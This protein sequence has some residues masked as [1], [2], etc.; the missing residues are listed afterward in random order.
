MSFLAKN[1]WP[2]C[3]LAL[4]AS[5]IP[6]A[7]ASSTVL[8]AQI[9]PD[10][11]LGAESSIVTPEALIRGELADEIGGGAIRGENL[12]HSFVEFNVL[13]DQRVYFANPIA[14]ENILSRVTGNN[15]SN[16]DGLLGVNGA[17]NL[18]L[19]NPNGIIFGPNARLDIQGSFTATTAE[20]IS[21]ADDS[22]FSATPTG[23]ELLSVSVPLGVQFN[24]QPQGDITQQGDLTVG[25]SETLTLF[26]DTVLNSGDLT[27]EGGTVQ[28]L[29]NQVSVI[30]QAAMDV[31][32]PTEAGTVQIGGDYQGQGPLP[33]ANVTLVEAGVIINADARQAGDGGR[34]IVWADGTTQ[35][36]GSIS[37]QG[38]SD[39]GDGG[40]VEV[41]G[42]QSLDFTG[43]VNTQAVNGTVGQLLLDPANIF[44]ANTAPA[45]TVTVGLGNGV[46]TDFIYSAVEDPGQNSHL[47]P[48]T[49]EALLAV[50]DLT[51]A[52]ENVIVVFDDVSANSDTDLTL[53]ATAIGV[54]GSLLE[55]SGGGSLVLETPQ[56]TGNFVVIDDG[57]VDTSPI[58][59][60][61]ALGGNVRITTHDLE[62]VNDGIVSASTFADVDA[63]QVQIN[64]TGDVLVDGE[65]SLITS[66]VAPGATGDS[67][68]VNIV[69]NNLSVLNNAEV[70]AGTFEQG[71]AGQ[72]QISVT[73][74]VLLDG[75]NSVI[76]SQVNSG[77]TG[78]SG[79]IFLTTNNLSVLNDAQVSAGTFGDGDA[80]QVQ[81]TTMGDVLLDGKN[82]VISSQV[83][84]GAIGD[85]GGIVLSTNN[86]SVLNGSVVTASTFG[87]G[88]AGPVQI[89][90]ADKILIDGDGSFLVSGVFS[91]AT[92]DS[93]G[94]V[95]SAN[96]LSVLNDAE[97]GASTFSEGDTGLVQIT[98]KGDVL[99]D[100]ENS[101]IA[102]QVNSS[103]TG[104]SGG[105]ILSAN[106]LSIFNNAAVS[107]STFSEGNAGQVQI[108]ATGD[109]LVDG[110]GSLI[111]SKVEPGATGDSG[112]ILLTGKSVSITN[113]GVISASTFGA[114]NSGQIRMTARG[115]VLVDG[116]RSAITSQVN[117]GGTGNSGGILLSA[118][119][120]SVFNDAQISGSTFGDGDAGQVQIA[121]IGDV[122]VDGPGSFIVSQVGRTATGNSNGIVLSAST[123]AL[124]NRGGVSASTVG[125][126]NS[127]QIKITSTEQV[128]VEDG[129]FL[130]SQVNSE[131]TGD[132]N[133]IQLST[134]HLT[135]SD[136]GLISAGTFGQG[137]AGNVL[138]RSLNSG[139]L[140]ITLD[141]GRIRA[142]TR[143]ANPGG[144]LTLQTDGDLTIQGKGEISVESLEADSGAAGS[145][146]VLAEN[147]LLDGAVELSAQTASVTGGG[148]INFTVDDALVM[149]RGSFI[150]AESTNPLGGDGG[151]VFIDTGFLIGAPGENNDIIAN[152]VGGN[153]GRIEVN[154][155]NIFGFQESQSGDTATLRNNTTNDLSASSGQGI[156][157]EVALNT[158]NVD[159]AS[160]LG[161]LPEGPIDAS[162]LINQ[163]LCEA[164]QG[165]EFTVTGR[166]GLPSAPTDAL[167]N[168]TPWEDWSFTE[169]TAIDK[170]LNVID[171]DA[172][173]RSATRLVEAQGAMRAADG[174]I[175]LLAE[176]TLAT[177]IAANSLSVSCRTVQSTAPAF[178]RISLP[179]SP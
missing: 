111:A 75:K 40:F 38:G 173:D 31:S 117:S 158:L 141:D 13:Q 23:N 170:T 126:G 160:G 14:I 51:L 55:Q 143:S 114:G 129:A 88:D 41:S 71:N 134:N 84:S 131:A 1:F 11:S 161:Q 177:P 153:G 58:P 63:G 127:G 50:N 46:F 85:S 94:I 19:M 144:N 25:A 163:S 171:V 159:P 7:E 128:I 100:G 64:A 147:V 155:I 107:A 65:F 8:V 148:I 169:D 29:G 42:R 174:R 102:S 135:V 36:A 142:R 32:A 97:L 69:A 104:N 130:I 165:S 30:G 95:L 150:N 112:G 74:D 15:L 116:R 164:G 77:A 44:I 34:V 152:A 175:V 132:S 61:T 125:D 154:A 93:G 54:I 27:T 167:G 67:G 66:R 81:I 172:A 91:G 179:P 87:E 73:G 2:V 28:L 47:T 4:I 119:N 79:G 45:G 110:E 145:L 140:S 99:V 72:V 5:G 108:T 136:L 52:A 115:N 17:A 49:V 26:G 109:V 80:G 18:F 121:A 62:V 3:S 124:L 149:R 56:T 10:N 16:I 138:V 166:G 57:L 122:L 157:G 146:N 90:A 139:D 9:V 6:A 176:P 12:F 98:A 120:L 53:N 168:A 37:A 96:D 113:D 137:N 82:S 156:E 43:T 76:S 118:D 101:L 35:F 83:S 70:D 20:G 89:D 60:A 33:T 68:G 24:D 48:A 105:V 103:A 39:R 133:S 178:D 59:G 106:N 151:N 22:E 92:G 86:L 78:D 162:Q 21:F 123:L